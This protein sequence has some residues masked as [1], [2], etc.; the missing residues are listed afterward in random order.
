MS[1]VSRLL[2]RASVAP[3][4]FPPDKGARLALMAE[5]DAASQ[6]WR[7]DYDIAATVRVTLS[8]EGT[9]MFEDAPARPEISAIVDV[10]NELVLLPGYLVSGRVPIDAPQE[11]FDLLDAAV[12]RLIYDYLLPLFPRGSEPF[13]MHE[14]FKD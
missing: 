8:L 4:D 13:F 12:T 7:Q 10:I 6:E 14:I 11:D 3:M 5:I 9:S 2:F 1:N